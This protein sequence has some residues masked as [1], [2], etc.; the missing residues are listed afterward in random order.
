MERVGVAVRGR[1]PGRVLEELRLRD[2]VPILHEPGA[3]LRRQRVRDGENAELQRSTVPYPAPDAAADY[4]LAL[5]FLERGYQRCAPQFRPG[6]A[7]A[8]DVLKIEAGLCEKCR[9]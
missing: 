5:E 7:A 4:F 9:K 1:P 3:E 6:V 8:V 2:V